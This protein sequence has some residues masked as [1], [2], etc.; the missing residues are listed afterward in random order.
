MYTKIYTL[1][2]S[3]FGFAKG[4][5][6]ESL[7]KEPK[8]MKPPLSVFVN[9]GNLDASSLANS[10][11][12]ELT[13]SLLE[14]FDLWE[15]R[16]HIL[17]DEIIGNAGMLVGDAGFENI[18]RAVFNWITTKFSTLRQ[19]IGADFL[20]GY[21]RTTQKIDD[22]MILPFINLL[23]R[24]EIESWAFAASV[25]ALYR[26]A[27]GNAELTEATRQQLHSH[28]LVFRE[29]MIRQG[30]HEGISQSLVDL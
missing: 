16:P 20:C 27:F 26:L 13:L 18:D 1:P 7:S 29:R 2:F 15:S 24:I 14:W 8:K 12:A 4:P 11:E 30:I 25:Y 28:L 17:D 9:A 10:T 21:W 22:A 6:N 23:D 19:E 3:G 5:T